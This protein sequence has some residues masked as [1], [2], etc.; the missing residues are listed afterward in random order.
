ML[1]FGKPLGSLN[2]EVTEVKL[3][4]N[5]DPEVLES[6]LKGDD[7]AFENMQNIFKK[8]SK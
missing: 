1:R 5:A 8:R 4:Q 2:R 6:I 7:K 3:V